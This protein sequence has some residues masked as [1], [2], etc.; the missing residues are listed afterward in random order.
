MIAI[1]QQILSCDAIIPVVIELPESTIQHIEM[2]IAKVPRDLIDVFFVI[3]LG[4]GI[5]Q[6]TPSYLTQG[7]FPRMALIDTVKYS[8]HHG[9]GIFLLKL[10]M[11]GQ[12]LE[13]LPTN[14]KEV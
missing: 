7:Y 9:N 4:K 8:S 11:I 2:L 5:Q 1:F 10:G 12:K 3:H 14:E 6:V 13:T